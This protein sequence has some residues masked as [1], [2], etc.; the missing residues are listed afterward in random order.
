MTE[1][2]TESNPPDRDAMAPA[3]PGRDPGAG[4]DESLL[5]PDDA[6]AAATEPADGDDVLSP[7]A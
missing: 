6:D 7:P 4:H 3:D 1:H 2:P 5:E